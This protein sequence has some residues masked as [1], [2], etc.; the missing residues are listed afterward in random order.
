M[1]PVLGVDIGGTFTDFVL[2]D[3]AGDLRAHFKIP[4]TPAAPAAAVLGGLADVESQLRGHLLLVHSTTVGINTV[5]ERKGAR[6]GLITSRGF[7]DVLELR[8]RDRPHLYGLDAD[9][10]PLIPRRL[11]LEVTERMSWDGTPLRSPD[12]EELRQ[13]CQQLRALGIEALA[14]VFLHAYANPDHEL[15]ALR[16]AEEEIDVPVTLSHR[17][18][19][20]AREFERTS[21]AV[22]N[23]YLQPKVGGYL[24]D[25]ARR[26]RAGGFASEPLVVQ[27]N[28]GVGALEE[29]AS[30]PVRTLMSGPSA[31]VV[32]ALAVARATD[33]PN[34]IT[35]DIGGTSTDVS[36]VAGFEVGYRKD[37]QIDFGIP[38]TT[39]TVDVLSVGAG[40]GSIAH[41]DHGGFLQVGP[42]SAG[43]E[44]G[45]A[46][47]VRG[48][49]L[50]TVT[51]ANLL[52]GR[53]GAD[54]QMGK[55]L[56]FELSPTAAAAAIE[57]DVASRLSIGIYDAALAIVEVANT[58]I[59]SA[60]RL[61]SVERGHDPRNFTLI[62][63]GGAGPLHLVALMRA[64]EI[65]RGVVPLRP[66]V[67]SALGCAIAD[68][69]HDTSQTVNRPLAE[70][71]GTSLQSVLREH[72]RAGSALLEREGVP[73]ES[74]RFT[75][76][77][78][79]SYRGQAHA[80]RVSVAA[81]DQLPEIESRF[82]AVFEARYGRRLD[83][84]LFVF[85]IHTRS[86]GERGVRLKPLPRV[87]GTAGSTPEPA[88][89]REMH[90]TDGPRDTPVFA[91]DRLGAGDEIAGPAA[92]EQLD[93][94]TLVELGS[95]A[96]VDAYGNLVIELG[97]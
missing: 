77:L 40:G 58:K 9:H 91:R 42:A 55:A 24:F 78:E 51:D 75:H 28:G 90:F 15:R 97:G 22:V 5:L 93:C 81:G 18:L 94:T 96:R 17:V 26:F 61:V 47:Y 85:S 27:A 76:E 50:A 49:V 36:V 1:Q 38:V 3:E 67:M 54:S 83:L 86:S 71:V 31:G 19:F 20:E 30:H 33:T 2:V 39:P 59:A 35:C 87:A 12:E 65:P 7:R 44:P 53:I 57:R 23:A 80:L 68:F 62:A 8:R 32:G 89:R 56:G 95:R 66:G 34:F 46:C 10:R 92:I 37:T 52:L 29:I 48:G 11:R 4:S 63:Y 45:P 13:A 72:V 69:A 21:T 64:L 6:V 14:I 16:I 41:V 70:V 73:P 82:A 74:R 43:A 88:T 60:V 25:L 84:P 79:A